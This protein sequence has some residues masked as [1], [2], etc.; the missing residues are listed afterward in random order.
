MRSLGRICV[1]P[2]LMYQTPVPKQS[3]PTDL[4]APPPE[5]LPTDHAAGSRGNGGGQA[6]GEVAGPRLGALRIKMFRPNPTPGS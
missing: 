3:R 5:D 6:A 1:Q 4:P 2:I